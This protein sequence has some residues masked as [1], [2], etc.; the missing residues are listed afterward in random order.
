[1][2]GESLV[3][4]ARMLEATWEAVAESSNLSPP[5]LIGWCGRGECGET[6]REELQ[7]R[8]STLFFN[9]F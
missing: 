5:Y 8:G 7:G 1:M 9:P 4:N 3:T 2:V 6:S